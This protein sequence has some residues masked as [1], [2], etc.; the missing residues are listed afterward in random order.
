MADVAQF[1]MVYRPHVKEEFQ[2]LSGE[3]ERLEGPDGKEL[4]DIPRALRP[5]ED[6]PAPAR[7]MAMWDSIMLTYADR[8]RVIPPDYRK[9]VNRSN[10]DV[11][12]SLLVEGYVAGVWRPVEGGVDATAFHR[13]PD[14]V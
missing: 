14:D 9:L 5:D 11:L 1:A 2:A 12:P 7:L 13:P 4:Y 8:S 10:S 6:M 3:M